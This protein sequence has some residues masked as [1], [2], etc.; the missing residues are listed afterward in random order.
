MQL[1]EYLG[2][3]LVNCHCQ[4][5][6]TLDVVILGSSELSHHAGTCLLIDS[7]DLRHDQSAAALC[8][9]FKVC[10]HSRSDSAVDLSQVR[11]HWRHDKTVLDLNIA[12]PAFFK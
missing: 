11:S 2:S 3:V 4:L 5:C 12:D 9:R 1:D 8:S 6:D 10:E 7:A